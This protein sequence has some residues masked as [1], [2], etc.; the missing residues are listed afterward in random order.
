MS[1]PQE[2]SATQTGTTA[3]SVIQSFA[4]AAPQAP[5]QALG[6][7][8]PQS[9]LASL[10]QSRPQ[11]PAS[12]SILP[13]TPL[14]GVQPP[15][16]TSSLGF[17]RGHPLEVAASQPASQQQAALMASSTRGPLDA[18]RIPGTSVGHPPIGQPA[19]QA[20]QARPTMQQTVVQNHNQWGLQRPPAPTMSQPS[21][22]SHYQ[23]YMAPGQ[24]VYR[25]AAPQ[26]A[27]Q[28]SVAHTPPVQQQ[29]PLTEEDRR[30]IPKRS[31][32]RLA[33]TAGGGAI[34]MSSEA[35]A[36]LMELAEDWLH[37]AL[38]FGC[39]SARKRGAEQLAPSDLTPYFERTWNLHVPG[40]GSETVQ[41][42]KRV[43]ASELHR[44]RTAAVRRTIAETSAPKNAPAQAPP[45]MHDEPALCV[46]KQ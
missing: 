12:V 31:I 39:A 27:M 19:S 36:A 5:L 3:V 45:V 8:Q 9:N 43:A 1:Q 6:P 29:R 44:T 21:S 10:T 38:I 32:E 35:E 34:N 14:A 11:P 2:N 23:S 33:T 15:E 16:M 28:P 7:A 13:I 41:P 20:Y 40:F 17:A 4:A 22:I 26:A 37:T 24:P 42:Y 18:A 25:P 30:I 46:E